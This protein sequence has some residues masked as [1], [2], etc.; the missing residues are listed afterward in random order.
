MIILPAAHCLSRLRP[1]YYSCCSYLSSE[2]LIITI[3]VMNTPFKSKGTNNKKIGFTEQWEVSPKKRNH[4]GLQ[5][6]DSERTKSQTSSSER[7]GEASA[8][9]RNRTAA[10]PS[11]SVA[12]VVHSLDEEEVCPPSS[13]TTHRTME[14]FNSSERNLF[15]L[16][17]SPLSLSAFPFQLLVVAPCGK[18]RLHCVLTDTFASF[19]IP[20]GNDLST[21]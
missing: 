21:C 13:I 7:T 9:G 19:V 16:F 14:P 18:K 3:I 8:A 11:L 17:A 12:V 10:H 20:R 6:E 5:F 1:C 4:K 2:L 15:R